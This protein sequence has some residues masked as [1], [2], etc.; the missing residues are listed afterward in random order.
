M[1]ETWQPIPRFPDYEVSDLGRIRRLTAAER[2]YVGRIIK[3][4]T[5]GQWG[6]KSCQ[7]GRGNRVQVHRM[8]LEAFVGPCPLEME[9]RHLNGD[10]ADNRLVNLCWGTKKENALDKQRHGT[11][12][13]KLSPEIIEQI[14]QESTGANGEQTRMGKKYGVSQVRISQILKTQRHPPQLK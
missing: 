2:T 6:H 7:L 3:P 8:V 10:P 12:R 9:C 13:R 1:N 5:T 14:K 4:S 11:I